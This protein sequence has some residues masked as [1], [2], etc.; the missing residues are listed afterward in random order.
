[1]NP[2]DAELKAIRTDLAGATL[3]GE[4]KKSVLAAFDHLPGLYRDLERTCES[5]FC[6]QILQRVQV[7]LKTL[8]D[9]KTGSPDAAQAAEGLVTRLRAMHAQFGIPSLGLKIPAPRKPARV[10]AKRKAV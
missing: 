10:A 2:M 4:V 7:M 3:A 8:D 5:R 6:D 1:G 9:G